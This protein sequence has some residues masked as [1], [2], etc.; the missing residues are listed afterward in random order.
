MFMEEKRNYSDE[1]CRGF[2][3]AVQKMG[4]EFYT[5]MHGQRVE[6]DEPQTLLK[7]HL[8]LFQGDWIGL[9]DFDLGVG[10][11]STKYFYNAATGSTSESLI[12]DAESIEQALRWVNAI[13]NNEPII[14]EDIEDIREEAPEEYAMY[15]RLGVES[16]LGVPYRNV[17]DGLMVVRNPKRFKR[18]YEALNIMSY[19]V[20][21]EI[22]ARR[23]RKNIERRAVER[24]PETINEVN[25]K[26]FGEMRITSKDLVMEAADIPEAVRLL[27]AY[28]VVNP[29][30]SMCLE[31]LNEF[32]KA[33]GAPWKNQ[34]YRF[35]NK[36]KSE[37]ELDDKYQLIVTT[38]RGYRLNPNLHINADVSNAMEL[39]KAIEDSSDI[40]SK[41]ELCRKCLAMY[42]GEFL[43]GEKH[44]VIFLD[45]TRFIYKSMFLEK[46]DILLE[47]L[48]NQKRYEAVVGT[49]TSVLMIAEASVDAY[50]WK[51]AAYRKLGKMDLMKGSF[52]S[53]TRILDRDE[54]AL[55]LEKVHKIFM[56]EEPELF[57]ENSSVPRATID[58]RAKDLPLSIPNYKGY[59]MRMVKL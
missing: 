45:E 43:Q 10:A 37:R 34:I 18:C 47:L 8:E 59:V 39:M 54:L 25:I 53:A 31:Q 30:K 58:R 4:A 14:I 2:I 46:M 49:S 41:V 28:L 57:A 5:Y 9:I 32:Y 24:E 11:W 52:D 50:C 7:R 35:R 48:Y 51:I 3:E 15:K 38:E 27:I 16:V 26:L 33:S 13:K 19:I 22:I 44:D 56:A 20:T 21:N 42:R 36:W 12:E 55:L 40:D 23:R 1:E 6:P 17:S 29:N